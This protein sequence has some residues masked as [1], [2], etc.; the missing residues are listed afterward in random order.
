[1]SL[2]ELKKFSNELKE[3][4]EKTGITLQQISQKTKIDIKF[5]KS[6]EES[7][8]DI[9]PEI[10]IK[11]FIKEYGFRRVEFLEKRPLDYWLETYWKE[12]SYELGKR[13]L[14]PTDLLDSLNLIKTQA[15]EK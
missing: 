6:I 2:E 1:M 15:A 3:H 9:L 13:K 14:S 8:F 4:R 10:Y 11:A 7:N 12:L 5:L